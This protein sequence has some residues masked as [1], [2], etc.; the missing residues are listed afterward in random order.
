M[1]DWEWTLTI[2]T[3]RKGGPGSGHHGHA[4]RPGQRGG[5]A[6]GKGTRR[7]NYDDVPELE[8]TFTSAG[9]AIEWMDSEGVYMVRGATSKQ[10]REIG[11]TLKDIKEKV[12][13]LPIREIGIDKNWNSEYNPGSNSITINPNDNQG[14][15]KEITLNVIR[16]EL[17][18]VSSLIE[19]S[20]HK[21]LREQ[22]ELLQSGAYREAHTLYWFEEGRH[23]EAIVRH[24][25]GHAVHRRYNENS[26]R[27]ASGIMTGFDN[28]RREAVRKG[29]DREWRDDYGITARGRD[30]WNECVAENFVAWSVGRTDLMNSKMVEMFD[31]IAEQTRQRRANIER[32]R[33]R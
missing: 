12:G 31:L 6:P 27:S 5:S 10:I 21:R 17:G 7:V 13:G 24:E 8:R 1:D 28:L 9:K 26:V 33:G 20:Y 15:V 14:G 32:A 29:T 19:T 11:D 30:S 22:R 3:G 25:M 23:I 18:K 16:K 2:E 4:G